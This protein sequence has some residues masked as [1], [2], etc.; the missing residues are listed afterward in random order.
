MQPSG[1]R[2]E[3]PPDR[4]SIDR[5]LLAAA[6]Q[7]RR[8]AA[9]PVIIPR[10][11]GTGP[12]PLS[13]SQQRM[14]FLEQ[15]E[16]GAPT[17]NGAC[18]IEIRGKLDVDALRRAFELA[19]ERHESLRTVFVLHGREPRQ[20]PL[21]DWSL[22]LATIDLT[23]SSVPL[24]LARHLRAL[25]R[26]PFD[27][28]KDLMIR[29][30]LFRLARDVHILLVRMHHIAADA[31]SVDVLFHEVSRAYAS[32]STGGVPDLPELAIQYAD[33]AR[34][35]HDR[36]QG[37][38]L[39]E[40]AS[41]WLAELGDAPRFLPLPTDRPRPPLQRHE[42]VRQQIRLRRELASGVR[43][44]ASSE[45]CTVYMVLLGA[46]ATLLY[47]LT[48]SADVLVGTPIANRTAPEL[49]SLI[50]FFTNTVA[51]R[52]RLGGNPTFREVCERVRTT[53][54]GA[55][56]HQELPFDRVVELLNVPRDP[57]YNPIFQVNFRAED[58]ARSPLR[59]SGTETSFVPVD[60]GFS[61][62]DLALELHVEADGI[63]GYF[64]FDSD[65]F[66]AATVTSFADDFEALLEQAVSAPQ[67][68]VLSMR[69][70]RGRSRTGA[71]GV[72]IPRRKARAVEGA[73]RKDRETRRE[74]G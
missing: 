52:I 35:Q 22:E 8:Q 11:Q 37:K 44:V 4:P 43:A 72:R 50:G 34:W 28:G 46:F 66:D 49:M 54:L 58:G 65:L 3:S 32:L 61:R 64:E 57:A 25:S 69:L 12:A 41:Y 63:G 29:P 70:P 42:G 21:D 19:V 24:D 17:S 15:W 53:A 62:F 71:A 16:P 33:F 18:A 60:V 59:L 31:F 40:L 38:L 6:L 27:L 30:T 47:R 10:R 5:A 67:T 39:E 48:G 14:W 56:Q 9:S 36:L 74:T 1:G 20:V 2:Q 68:P 55:Y 23:V 51:L 26:E 7:R 45:S 13:F 73:D